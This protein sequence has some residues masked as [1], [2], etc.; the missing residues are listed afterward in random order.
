M[1]ELEELVLTSGER[2]RGVRVDSV[3]FGM[4][5]TGEDYPGQLAAF[6]ASRVRAFG[7]E[8]TDVDTNVVYHAAEADPTLRHGDFPVRQL[9]HLSGVLTNL[10]CTLA[11]WENGTDTYEVLVA[12]TGERELT[13][14]MHQNL[15]V[16]AWDSEPE[17]TLV[18]LDCPNCSETLFWQLPATQT[19]A[20]ER[21]DCGAALFDATGCPLPNVT[22]HE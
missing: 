5:W 20:D 22:L 10:G 19:L 15:P 9:D 2:A 16:R 17:E 4:D 8:P 1:T 12:L 21:C 11:V 3:M 7:A 13:G 6:V 18:V 14:L